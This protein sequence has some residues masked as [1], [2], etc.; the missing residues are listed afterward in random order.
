MKVKCKVCGEYF[1]KENVYCDFCAAK[2]GAEKSKYDDVDLFENAQ[3]MTSKS[4]KIHKEPQENKKSSSSRPE[5]IPDL[6][7]SR[8]LRK[9]RKKP[10]NIFRSIIF[11]IVFMNIITG[12]LRDSNVNNVE[13]FFDDVSNEITE[14][15]VRETSNDD[16]TYD[17]PSF[18]QNTPID[19]QGSASAIKDYPEGIYEGL[20]STQTYL[21]YESKELRF[22]IASDDYK[23]I[24]QL[25]IYI[26]LTATDDASSYYFDVWDQNTLKLLGSYN[27]PAGSFE[28]ESLEFVGDPTSSLYDDPDYFDLQGQ[29][30]G[31]SISGRLALPYTIDNEIYYFEFEVEKANDDASSL[32]TRSYIENEYY[33][34]FMSDDGSISLDIYTYEAEQGYPHSSMYYDGIFVLTD[35]SNSF[36]PMPFYLTDGAL[37]AEFDYMDTDT[38]TIRETDFDDYLYYDEVDTQ[39]YRYFPIQHEDA[40]YTF[41]IDAEVINEGD[42][43]FLKGSYQVYNRNDGYKDQSQDFYVRY[44]E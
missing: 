38:L 25:P 21:N 3:S 9:P 17:R 33:E 26:S 1:E 32:L 8:E 4:K 20:L 12:F 43:L 30:E 44:V 6:D 11:F 28:G 14:E 40:R 31:L 39:L 19:V 13:D 23:E 34:S 42:D 36:P 2:Y 24:Y 35:G 29:F 37:Y 10:R 5:P 41:Y 18:P 7:T 16:I 15:V 22:E 27:I